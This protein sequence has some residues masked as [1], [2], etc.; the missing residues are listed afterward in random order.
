MPAGT[1]ANWV[2]EFAKVAGLP[3]LMLLYMTIKDRAFAAG[4]RAQSEALR[5]M[6]ENLGRLAGKIE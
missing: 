3:G 2:I 6:A 1:D 4:W 5:E